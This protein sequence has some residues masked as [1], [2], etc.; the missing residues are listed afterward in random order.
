MKHASDPD[1]DADLKVTASHAIF[2]RDGGREAPACVVGFQFSHASMLERFFNITS[3]D[4]VC[5]KVLVSITR[6]NGFIK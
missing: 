2:P 3:I 4:H 1:E 6:L 5:I